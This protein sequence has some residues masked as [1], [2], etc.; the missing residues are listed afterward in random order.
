MRVLDLMLKDLYQIVKDWKTFV[1]LLDMPMAFTLLLGFA[2]SE[3]GEDPRLPVAVLDRD[4]AGVLGA[5]LIA[6]MDGSDAIR[7]VVEGGATSES[8]AADVQ[9]EKVAAAVIVPDGYSARVLDG[10]TPPLRV[11]ADSASNAGQTAQTN[12]QAVVNRL[13]TSVQAAQAAV[14][15]LAEADP[16]RYA[17]ASAREAALADA[18]DDAVDAWEDPPFAVASRR[19][20]QE[21]EDEAPNAFAHSSAGTMAQFAIAGLIGAA[22]V[23]VAER[24]SR[25]LQRMLTTSMRK[26]EVL[27]GHFLAMMMMVLTQLVILVLFGQVAF[28]VPYAHAPLAIAVVVVA[29]A[30]FTGAMGLLIGGRAKSEEQVVIFSLLPMF[31]LSGLGG[32]WVPLEFTSETVQIIGRFT[33][34]AWAIEGLENVTMRG[35]DLSSVV[36]PALVVLGFGVLCLTVAVWQF[37]VE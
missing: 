26:V 11:I 35:M 22:E 34:T 20:G 15:A 19:T 25:T 10:E 12:L 8:L 23:V 36:V 4:Q 17:A 13:L 6:L 5:P 32:A 37:R 21:A 16:D 7:P 30:F 9:D 31:V 29:F 1:F 28:G 14:D 3:E 27:A 2:F 24:K 33:P 18:L